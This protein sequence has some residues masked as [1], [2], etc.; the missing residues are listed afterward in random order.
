MN[1]CHFLE[2]KPSSFN[3]LEKNKISLFVQNKPRKGISFFFFPSFFFP[4]EFKK[5]EIFL[6]LNLKNLM[7]GLRTMNRMFHESMSQIFCCY[8]VRR[9]IKK[10][11]L[12]L[13]LY[14]KG[15]KTSIFSFPIDSS[16]FFSNQSIFLVVI[17]IRPIYCYLNVFL[18]SYF[19]R[20]A[21]LRRNINCCCAMRTLPA[22]LLLLLLFDVVC[23]MCYLPFGN[24]DVDVV[25]SLRFLFSKFF[26]DD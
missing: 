24:V 9:R 18:L 16:I 14:E 17:D 1:C 23:L 5:M 25:F 11:L 6:S 7:Q 10:R 26:H 19:S 13:I 21:L 3:F 2:Q 12:N 8:N 20:S 15:T 22:S 4:I